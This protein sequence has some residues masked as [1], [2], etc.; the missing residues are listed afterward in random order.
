MAKLRHNTTM[1]IAERN[2]E[3]VNVLYLLRYAGGNAAFDT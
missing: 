1:E 3:K 2:G